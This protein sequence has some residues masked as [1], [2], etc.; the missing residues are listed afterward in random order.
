MNKSDIIKSK[1]SYLTLKDKFRCKYCKEE[2]LSED[3][4][5]IHC[6]SLHTEKK[7]E[8]YVYE[9]Y[10]EPCGYATFGNELFKN[11]CKTFHKNCYKNDSLFNK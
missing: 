6:I 1:Y 7:D 9:Y 4:I 8:K 2:S 11:H 3:M 10:C 5:Y